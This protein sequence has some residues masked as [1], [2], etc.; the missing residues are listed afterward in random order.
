MWKK[1]CFPNIQ[2]QEYLIQNFS[3]EKK[4]MARTRPGWKVEEVDLAG[5]GSCKRHAVKPFRKSP[6]C[7][8]KKTP[9]EGIK[10]T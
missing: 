9:I 3:P 5:D 1:P 8:I 10:H 7:E 6:S 2:F 4:E